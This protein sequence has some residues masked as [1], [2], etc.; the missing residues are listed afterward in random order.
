MTHFLTILFWFFAVFY[1]FFVIFPNEVIKLLTGRYYTTD[2]NLPKK[3]QI[4]KVKSEK[5]KVAA[6]TEKNYG[7]CEIALDRP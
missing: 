2:T 4:I 5:V 6:L 3:G 1:Y 7:G